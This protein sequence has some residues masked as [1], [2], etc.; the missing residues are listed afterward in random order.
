LRYRDK[1]MVQES[2]ERAYEASAGY[3]AAVQNV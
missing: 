2:I 1:T 3:L